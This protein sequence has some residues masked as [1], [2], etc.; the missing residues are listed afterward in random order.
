VNYLHDET[1]ASAL[2]RPRS[3]LFQ[4]TE[5]IAKTGTRTELAEVVVA[6]VVSVAVVVEP[7]SLDHP[8]LRLSSAYLTEIVP[9]V[10]RE[11]EPLNY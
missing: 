8:D 1:L 9:R 3:A 10:G 5:N 11:E 2:D 7:T 6:V 4:C